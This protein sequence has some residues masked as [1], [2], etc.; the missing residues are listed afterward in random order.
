MKQKERCKPRYVRRFCKHTSEKK[1]RNISM[2]TKT[3]ELKVCCNL[4]TIVTKTNLKNQ[5]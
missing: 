1:N 3:S 5:P 2:V 4:E